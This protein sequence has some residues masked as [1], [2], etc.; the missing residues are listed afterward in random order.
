MD[1]LQEGGARQFRDPLTV[2]LMPEATRP[3]RRKTWVRAG[4]QVGALPAPPPLSTE[5]CNPL[6]VL[7]SSEAEPYWTCNNPVYQGQGCS[8]LQRTLTLRWEVSLPIATQG[9]MTPECIPAP[10]IKLCHSLGF[11]RSL[12]NMPEIPAAP[13]SQ[14]SGGVLLLKGKSS[15]HVT[16]GC[17]SH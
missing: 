10:Y 13:Y 6:P 14:L 17:I 1:V 2:K 15:I 12:E 7:G 8:I 4:P 11:K 3:R 5:G 16:S 9:H